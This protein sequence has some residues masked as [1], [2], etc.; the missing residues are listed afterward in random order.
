MT[1]EKFKEWRSTIGFSQT[2]AAKWLGVSRDTIGNYES[3]SRRDDGRD[4]SIPLAIEQAC[5]TIALSVALRD[6][7]PSKLSNT[8][9][10]QVTAAFSMM[11]AQDVSGGADVDQVDPNTQVERR[12]Q[13][14]IHADTHLPIL[15]L[16]DE[17]AVT[18]YGL[19]SVV[20]RSIY[21]I[22]KP[23][24]ALR[25]GKRADWPAQIEDKGWADP[26]LFVEAFFKALDIH[27]IKH[28]FD[29]QQEDALAERAA[30][31]LAAYNEHRR[32]AAKAGKG[33]VRLMTI[34]D[35]RA[36]DIEIEKLLDDG[37]KAP[38]FPQS[39]ANP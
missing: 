34:D 27:G 37:F 10:N 31:R 35:M 11:Q 7:D 28:D 5:H 30:D 33:G 23:R 25:R 19:E 22:D 17:W 20:A 9:R 6:R 24:L 8:M 3:G 18:P 21:Y 36:E 26:R 13:P 39:C 14:T 32:R 12:A 16:N 1:P 38:E 29:R 2:E 15:W 4:V